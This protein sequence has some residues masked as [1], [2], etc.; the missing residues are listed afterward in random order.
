MRA[1]GRTSKQSVSK[2]ETRNQKKLGIFALDFG[3]RTAEKACLA[4]KDMTKG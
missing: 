2:P 4:T 3:A 1:A